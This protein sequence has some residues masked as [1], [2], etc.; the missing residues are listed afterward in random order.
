MSRHILAERAAPDDLLDVASRIC[1]L[2]AQVASAAELSAWVRMHPG[3]P[4]AVSTALWQD[5]TLV[6]TWAMRG[7]LH[8][9]VA[10]E[11]PTFMAARRTIN[12]HLTPGYLKYFDLTHAQM[13]NLIES[14][15]TALD[16]R[17]LTRDEL[18]LEV[19]R[20]T[21]EARLGDLLRSGWG[22][23]LKPAAAL[24]YL[25]FGPNQGRNVTFVRPDQ[26]LGGWPEI[27]PDWAMSEVLRRYLSTYG[28]TT[29]DEFAQ[30]FGAALSTARR[31]FERLAGELTEVHFDGSRAYVLSSTL[32]DML[33]APADLSVRLL[34]NFDPY[35]IGLSPQVKRHIPPEQLP[36]VFRIAGWISPVVLV[37]GNIMGVWGYERGTNGL[38][39][40][41]DIF[42]QTPAIPEIISG[43]EA[44][45]EYLT[46]LLGGPLDL[47]FDTITFGG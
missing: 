31:A 8:L 14:I 40:T 24:G 37:D 42:E 11:L 6:K 32:D 47:R 23:F 39:V 28:P 12:R 36:R 33:A 3:E 35:M 38:K 41:V 7:T 43:I 13:V 2:H 29:R 46:G 44:E 45:A 18:A 27:D 20:I 17:C 5:R 25:C 9:I 16:G 10:D 22:S 30:W 26:W 4:G 34:S 19:G 15:G 1:G 21:G